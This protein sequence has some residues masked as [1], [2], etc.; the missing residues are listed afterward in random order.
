MA[1][2]QLEQKAPLVGSCDRKLI[3]LGTEERWRDAGA[4]W[5]RASD[6]E[7]V[8]LWTARSSDERKKGCKRRQQNEALTGSLHPC[9]PSKMW[10]APHALLASR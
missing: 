5:C 7:E 10:T 8:D 9:Y 4:G 3:D 2:L 1:G 6:G